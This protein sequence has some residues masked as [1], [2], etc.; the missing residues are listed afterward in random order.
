MSGNSPA[1]GTLQTGTKAY[2][3]TALTVVT[4]FILYWISDE[5]PFTAKEAAE[6]VVGALVAGGLVGGGT[7][8]TK[9]KPT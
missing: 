1:P 7:Y 2:V 4:A 3:A 9:N 8:V 6:G 5:D